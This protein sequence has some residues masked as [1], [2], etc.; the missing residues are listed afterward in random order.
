L[1][2]HE[3]THVYMNWILHATQLTRP[4]LQVVYNVFG[5][6]R[7]NEKVCDWLK[8][9]R[10]STP[11]HIG[12]AAHDQ[13]QLDVYGEVLDAVYTY[14]DL[15]EQFDNDTRKFIIGLG[16]VICKLWNQPDEGIW[17]IRSSPVHHTHSKVL[18]WVGLDRIIKLCRKYNWSNLP[19]QMFEN[20]LKD[21]QEQIELKGFNKEL[22]HYTSHFNGRDLD[23][24]LLILP[25]VEYCTASSPRMEST[26]KN[27]QDLL[28]SKS[29]LYRH[30]NINDGL[31]GKEGAFIVC[32]FW[33]IENLVQSGHLNQAI[34]LFN[35]TIQYA[36]PGGLLSEEIDP[37]TNELLGNYPQGFSHIGLINAAL[38]IDEAF[39]Q[40]KKTA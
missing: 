9:Y 36:S 5:H 15:V 33:L 20:V 22:N 29:F 19:I 34:D 6:S 7:M 16:E 18:A 25:L 31:P 32:N 8:G 28:S 37:D 21:I 17:E 23:A 40:S 35:N 39:K 38:A 12:N 2:Y 3:E 27:I 10:N 11:V 4:R 13:F 24:S 14:S 1:G 26:R 30:V